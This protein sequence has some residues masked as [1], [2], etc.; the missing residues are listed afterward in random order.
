MGG[1]PANIVYPVSPYFY[2]T[3]AAAVNPGASDI[4]CRGTLNLLFIS[5]WTKSFFFS[6]DE[7][8]SNSFVVVLLHYL[9]IIIIR[10]IKSIIHDDERQ[11]RIKNQFDSVKL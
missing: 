11:I 1:Y 4:F 2:G 5:T 7:R 6:S 9:N 3:A 10:K 8:A